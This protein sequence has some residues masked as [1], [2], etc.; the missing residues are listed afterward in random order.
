M[1][2]SVEVPL[3]IDATAVVLVEGLSDRF[4]VEAAA[5]RLDRDLDQEGV[6]VVAMGGVTNLGHF[7]TRFGPCASRMRITGLCD[8]AEAAAVHRALDRASVPR[9]G[10]FVCER[11]L[12]DELIRAL[13]AERVEAVIEEQGELA[14][15]RRLQQMPF[16]RG[17]PLTEQLHRFMGVRSGRKHRYAPL[18]VEA[19]EPDDIPRP[20]RDLLGCLQPTADRSLASNPGRSDDPP[21]AG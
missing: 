19:L 16:H 13:G 6:A 3:D 7:L 14:S 18:L 10:F 12:E 11:D 2:S 17:R 15:L 20:L 8:L 21:R 1:A 5:R 4:A 9:D